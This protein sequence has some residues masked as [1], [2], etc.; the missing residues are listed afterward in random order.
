M[1]HPAERADTQ[2]DRG[3]VSDSLDR[4]D[5]RVKVARDAERTAYGHY[6]LEFTE[7]YVHVPELDCHIRVTE[8]G[9]GPPVVVNPGGVGYGVIWTPLLPELDGYTAFVMDRPGGGF[10]EGSITR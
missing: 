4:D 3:H 6:G 7:H 1:S 2:S 10:S 8:V 9:D 5:P